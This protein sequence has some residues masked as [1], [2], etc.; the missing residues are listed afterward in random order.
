MSL[1]GTE[2]ILFVPGGLEI[3]LLV[4]ILVLL[5]GASRLPGLA[6]SVGRSVAEF[7][8]GR[9][10]SEEPATAATDT[11]GETQPGGQAE[12]TAPTTPEQEEDPF[13]YPGAEDTKDAANN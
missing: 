7:Q 1:G 8:Q 5:F 2:G 9:S 12:Q 3:G 13:V 4:A 6:R 11:A 10:G